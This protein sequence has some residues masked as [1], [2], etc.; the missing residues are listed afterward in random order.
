MFI[1]LIIKHKISAYNQQRS[2]NNQKM[3]SYLL[4]MHEV[5]F[6]PMNDVIGIYL[7]NPGWKRYC[8][9]VDNRYTVE[10]VYKENSYN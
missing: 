9:V 6:L 1:L 5:K 4:H 10:I 3:F 8:V 7:V 2:Y